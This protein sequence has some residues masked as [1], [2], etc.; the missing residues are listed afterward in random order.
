MLHTLPAVSGH[1][2]LERSSLSSNAL[3]SFSYESHVFSLDE[4]KLQQSVLDISLNVLVRET[5]YSDLP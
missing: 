3:L 2:E 4:Q 5:K 1:G